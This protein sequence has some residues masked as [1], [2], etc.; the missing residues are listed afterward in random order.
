MCSHYNGSDLFQTWGTLTTGPHQ[1]LHGTPAGSS[2]AWFNT[3]QLHPQII[4][5]NILD[6]KVFEINPIGP[7]DFITDV[8]QLNKAYLYKEARCLVIGYTQA[9]PWACYVEGNR[10][11]SEACF[12]CSGN[13]C[14]PCLGNSSAQIPISDYFIIDLATDI[15]WPDILSLLEIDVLEKYE[16]VTKKVGNKV[17][18][19]FWADEGQ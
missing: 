1:E 2:K 18:P 4:F 7:K 3:G 14:F 10:K 13:E 19:K 9:V 16:L 17:L 11:P 12:V 6:K 5:T 8:T 15:V